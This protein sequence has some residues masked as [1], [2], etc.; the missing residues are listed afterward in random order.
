MTT[1][2]AKL[3]AFTASPITTQAD[4]F[5]LARARAERDFTVLTDAESIRLAGILSN[6]EATPKLREQ[7]YNLLHAALG[8][9]ALLAARDNADRFQS[10]EAVHNAAEIALWTVVKRWDAKRGMKLSSFVRIMLPIELERERKEQEVVDRTDW[11]EIAV[12]AAI[13]AITNTGHNRLFLT[14]YSD[15]EGLTKVIA[16]KTQQQP[17]QLFLQFQPFAT[18]TY[19]TTV[20]GNLISERAPMTAQEMLNVEV[21]KKGYKTTESK[22]VDVPVAN[23]MLSWLTNHKTNIIKFTFGYTS[24][25]P[26]KTAKAKT[27]YKL[28]F[29][30]E[31][32]NQFQ[33]S[34]LGIKLTSRLMRAKVFNKPFKPIRED[35][36]TPRMIQDIMRRDRQN[37]DQKFDEKAWTVGKIGF[38]MEQL[39]Q[40]TSY[41]AVITD[42]EGDETRYS[43]F[44]A[45]SERDDEE[46]EIET[47]QVDGEEMDIVKPRFNDDELH[48]AKYITERLQNSGLWDIAM[49]IPLAKFLNAHHAGRPGFCTLCSRYGIRVK[50][51]LQIVKVID[52]SLR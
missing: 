7:A 43:D 45:A 11:A 26:R 31:S 9:I 23:P 41:D 2:T 5:E 15:A 14:G 46:R 48:D 17:A 29:L 37:K 16:R 38:L 50:H 3:E 13:Q 35:D 34:V 52:A 25:W 22:T 24:N 19:L 8:P 27:G 4:S 10:F 12:K 33:Q 36:V 1:L 39:H 32:G 47:I 6:E 49:T 40:V 18:V 51:A 44:L 21:I 42:D 20:N 30:Q 28:A